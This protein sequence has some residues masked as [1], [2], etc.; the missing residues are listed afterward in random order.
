VTETYLEMKFSIPRKLQS[1]V[2]RS[3]A[4]ISGTLPVFPNI[5][6]KAKMHKYRPINKSAIA[7]FN[8]KIL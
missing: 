4:C 8:N 7:R 3:M 2:K 6:R 1:D 5:L